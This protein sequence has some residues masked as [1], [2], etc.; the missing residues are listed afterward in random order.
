MAVEKVIAYGFIACIALIFAA[1]ATT[2]P[3]PP[4]S[5]ELHSPDGK[6]RILIKAGNTISG[7]WITRGNRKQYVALWNAD[8]RAA[9]LVTR[10]GRPS[11]ADAMLTTTDN[12]GRLQL[13][14]PERKPHVFTVD[15]LSK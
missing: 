9:V 11:E 15:D 7:I 12:G 6:S 1:A 14:D 3:A 5:I 10:P 2:S 4:H 13:T 8:D